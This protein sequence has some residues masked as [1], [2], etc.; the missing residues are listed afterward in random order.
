MAIYVGRVGYG[1]KLDRLP[2]SRSIH[3]IRDALRHELGPA[4]AGPSIDIVV[5]VPGSLG[6]AEFEGIRTGRLSRA[7]QMVQAEIAVPRD[8]GTAAEPTGPLLELVASA[9]VAGAEHLKRAGISFDTAAHARALQ[10]T[11]AR[12]GVPAPRKLQLAQIAPIPEDEPWVE[13]RLSA[14]HAQGPDPFAV[15]N[16]LESRIESSGLGSFDG[17]EIGQGEHLLFFSGADLPALAALVEAEAA[18]LGAEVSVAIRK[19]ASD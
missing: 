14:S 15:E 13:V 19:A 18:K 17:N 5:H 11:A 7:E 10:R 16:E 4:N 3:A 8:L 9:I 1:P 2:I 6:E 12:L